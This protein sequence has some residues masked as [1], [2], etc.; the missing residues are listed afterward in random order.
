MNTQIA[1]ADSW[2]KL[3]GTYKTYRVSN[4]MQIFALGIHNDLGRYSTIQPYQSI[5][6]DQSVYTDDPIFAIFRNVDF[7]FIVTVILSLF[8]ILFT[9][10][11]VNGEKENGTM[12]LIFSNSVPRSQYIMAKFAGI[13]LG[14]VVSIL[15]PILIG[16]LLLFLFNIPFAGLDWIKIMILLLVALLYFSFFIAFGIL[17]SSF[18]SQSLTSFLVLLVCWIAFVFIIPRVGI[19]TAGQIY[20]IPSDSMIESQ[21][22]AFMTQ[23]M[24][25]YQADATKMVQRLS[26][27]RKVGP[28]ADQAEIAKFQQEMRDSLEAV[29]K[30][31]EQSN[32]E[33]ADK[34]YENAQNMKDNVEKV[35]LSLSRIS[36]ASVFQLAAMNLC[37]TDLSIKKKY[38]DEMNKFRTKYNA[39]VQKKMTENAGVGLQSFVATG[40]SL[41]T[42]DLPRFQAPVITLSESV[43][44]AI[45]DIVL[46][47]VFTAVSVTG[48]FLR[49]RKY[50]LR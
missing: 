40:K 14:L 33:Y 23:A 2:Y 12:R 17:V 22:R 6:Y 8:A 28:N 31:M 37:G 29:R 42:R 7:A 36:P 3:M 35:G 41:D 15:I 4:P 20:N 1:Q 49:F 34:L 19:M 26:A 38:Y 45:F 43:Q 44:P 18:T 27:N 47:F 24:T 30:Q 46:L 21:K 13:W 9:Y 50:D 32:T 25:K 11:S 48:A 5:R 10:D 39:F 16:I